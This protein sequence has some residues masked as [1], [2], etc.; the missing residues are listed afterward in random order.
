MP[1]LSKSPP[2]SDS[3]SSDSADSFSLSSLPMCSTDPLPASTLT[4]CV[5]TVTSYTRVLF[6]LPSSTITKLYEQGSTATTEAIVKRLQSLPT[7]TITFDNGSENAGWRDIE[8]QLNT[9][10]YFCHPYCSS[11]RGSDENTNG[12]LRDYHPK[13]TD[14]TKVS[15]EEL[16]M[17]EYTPKEA[18]GLENTIRSF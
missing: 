3:D 9:N 17:V 8:T 10:T 2:F 15:E 11:E 16:A 1:F 6:S 18:F 5:P 12:L 14:F 4:S 7:H 13:G